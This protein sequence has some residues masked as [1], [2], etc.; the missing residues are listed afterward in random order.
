MRN[1]ND[2]NANRELVNRFLLHMDCCSWTK[3]A[4]RLKAALLYLLELEDP[5]DHQVKEVYAEVADRTEGDWRAAER[6][7]RYG[8]KKM[9]R[10]HPEECSLLFYHSSYHTVCPC[11][12]DFLLMFHTESARGSIRLWVE[13]IEGRSLSIYGCG[14]YGFRKHDGSGFCGINPLKM[15]QHPVVS[16]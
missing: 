12:S 15:K 1:L 9:W 14:G 2:P 7:M 6:S 13:A 8:I 4:R 11:V 5:E 10:L 3:N 16:A